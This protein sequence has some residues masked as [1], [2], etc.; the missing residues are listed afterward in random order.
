MSIGAKHLE[1]EHPGQESDVNIT[2]VLLLVNSQVGEDVTASATGPM[3][4]LSV[5]LGVTDPGYVG[6][7]VTVGTLDG[8]EYTV[9]DLRTFS[10]AYTTGTGTGL[11]NFGWI[12]DM[13]V[14]PG[15]YIGIYGVEPAGEGTVPCVVVVNDAQGTFQL[16]SDIAP[17]EA[18]DVV[19]VGFFPTGLPL[20][21]SEP[22]PP[23]PPPLVLDDCGEAFRFEAC[24]LRTGIVRAILQPTTADWQTTLN[25]VGQ[26]SLNVPTKGVR[27]RDIWPHLTSLYMAR[28]SGGEATP[29]NPVCEGAFIID[30]FSAADTGTTMVGFR[31]IED[32]LFHRVYRAS[33]DYDGSATRLAADLVAYTATNGIP[34]TGDHEV[35]VVNTEREYFAWERKNIGEAITELVEAEPGIEWEVVHTKSPGGAWSSTMIFRDTVGTVRAIVLQS[36]VE[37]AGYGLDVDAAD[38]ATLVDAIGDGTEEAQLI[39]TALDVGVYP[40]FDATPPFKD[41]KRMSTLQT[42]ANGYL[43]DHREPVAVP[44]MT[45]MG[46][47]DPDPGLLRNG[48]IIERVRTSFGA[49]TYDGPARLVSTS[50][51][52]RE[53]AP[54]ARTYQFLSTGRASQT[55]LN[56]V[57]GDDCDDTELLPP[58]V[59]A[60][61]GTH[62]DLALRTG[63]QHSVSDYFLA[64]TGQTGEDVTATDT[65]SVTKIRFNRD[66][67]ALNGLAARIYFFTAT[68][69]GADFTVT[70]VSDLLT[71]DYITGGGVQ[72]WDVDIPVKEGDYLAFF[73]VDAEGEF[74]STRY[75]ES[76][77][78]PGTNLLHGPT[79]GGLPV[80][81]P[82]H[83]Y[84]LNLADTTGSLLFQGDITPGL[85]PVL[86]GFA[87]YE[88]NP[89]ETALPDGDGITGS[90][91]WDDAT[92]TTY[93][94][95]FYENTG[96][97]SLRPVGIVEPHTMTL[98]TKTTLT[99]RASLL[100][101][102]GDIA[103]T[104]SRFY[105]GFTI[106]GYGAFPFDTINFP[107]SPNI[108]PADVAAGTIFDVTVDIDWAALLASDIAYQALIDLIL[109]ALDAGTLGVTIQGRA[110]D[111]VV[112][113]ASSV[114]K[115]YKVEFT[116]EGS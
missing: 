34:L 104:G 57:I 31:S 110:E 6:F 89:N 52:L 27:A 100:S 8:D 90:D 51:S 97:L 112:V 96:D 63:D 3:G 115:I 78:D 76:S 73:G 54:V 2:G 103:A 4:G 17:P 111:D 47:G 18:D 5:R 67:A 60:V 49:I 44:S 114:T 19:P 42:Q 25:G 61:I 29:E 79:T 65:G 58:T 48:D 98:L 11:F 70:G 10:G 74:I 81:T 87:S 113:R 37:G 59:P 33:R 12:P 106:P 99:Y 84:T 94:S 53:G 91:P 62:G 66:S 21:G 93:T 80:P 95:S 40:Q 108:D 102:S 71:V 55:V 32:Y 20:L 24:D 46:T 69:D 15:D 105:A 23:P 75:L 77:D 116:V 7:I 13:E 85:L 64:I 35:G 82:G 43:A 28:I 30:K 92:D 45:I 39:A 88:I 26:G 101:A 9:R 107:N 50:W 41:I 72:E 1:I 16:S 38:H 14:E 36:D 86:L 56:Q 109:A 68:I 22:G 83:V